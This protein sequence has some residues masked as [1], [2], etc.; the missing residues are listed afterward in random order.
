MAVPITDIH[1]HILPGLDDGPTNMSDTTE[2]LTAMTEQGV[3]RAFCTSHYQSPHFDVSTAQMNAAFID[4][5]NTIATTRIHA[6]TLALGAEVRLAKSLAPDLES[7]TVPRLGE[8]HYVLVEF[9][10]MSIPEWALQF[11]YELGIRKLQP[12]MAHPERN[13]AIQKDPK[14]IETLRDAGLLMQATAQC[15]TSDEDQERRSSKLAWTMLEQ[16]YVDLIASD[17]HN[18]TSRPPGLL[19]AYEQISTRF[20]DKTVDTL[21]E[22]ANAVWEDEVCRPVEMVEKKTKVGVRGWFR[23]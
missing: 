15:F 17:T 10:T 14:L 1:A 6:P 4:V 22:N 13:V 23:R 20:G 18:T 9:E 16:G 2:L 7:G 8:T 12:I 5:T 19:R 11:V 21:M 3:H